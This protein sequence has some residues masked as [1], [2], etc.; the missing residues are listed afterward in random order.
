MPAAPAGSDRLL[1]RCGGW[2]AVRLGWAHDTLGV[3]L[4]AAAAA[5]HGNSH[6][7]VFVSSPR[8]SAGL[9]HPATPTLTDHR[10]QG[11]ERP[12]CFAGSRQLR[13]S[14][15]RASIRRSIPWRVRA[16][17]R[18]RFAAPIFTTYRSAYP[19]WVLRRF[20]DRAPLLAVTVTRTEAE[21]ACAALCGRVPLLTHTINDPAEAADLTRRGIAGVYT[22]E[23]L[24]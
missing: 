11:R 19:W 2:W 3:P 23:L 5:A 15:A 24:P 1:A 20:V 16:G 14:S 6:G 13:P 18:A 8:P 12:S 21:A 7:A 9:V 4:T 10:H 17:T 22:D